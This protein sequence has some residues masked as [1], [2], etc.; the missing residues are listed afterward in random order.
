M[1]ALPSQ[2][3]PPSTQT[4]YHTTCGLIGIYIYISTHEHT[5]VS[6][7]AQVQRVPVLALAVADPA[8]AQWLPPPSASCGHVFQFMV[9]FWVSILPVPK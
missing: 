1:I 8:L 5:P 9:A 3:Q 2:P 6:I 4:P 7:L